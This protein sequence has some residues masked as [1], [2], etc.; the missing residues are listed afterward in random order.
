MKNISILVPRGAAA[1]SCIEGSF[2]GFNRA[3]EVLQNMGKPPLFQVQLVGITKEAQV[4]DKLFTVHPDLEISEV[5]K[6]D[7]IIIPAVNGKMEE[8]IEINKE[9]FPWIV[10]QH[11]KG[12]EV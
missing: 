4:Y 6:T 12:A 11:E 10:S 3:N 5:E 1:L 9:F 7:L 8:V 2:V